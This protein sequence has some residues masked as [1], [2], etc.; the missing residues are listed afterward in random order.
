MYNN[1]FFT[2]IISYSLFYFYVIVCIFIVITIIYNNNYYF[3]IFLF[4]LSTLPQDL[5]VSFFDLSIHVAMVELTLQTG[6]TEKQ[7]LAL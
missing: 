6:A 7:R 2:H 5:L 4:I 1:I 3:F